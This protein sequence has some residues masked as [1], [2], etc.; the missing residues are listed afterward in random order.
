[1]GI[2]KNKVIVERCNDYDRKNVD[3]V[4][5]LFDSL[6][7]ETIGH[8]ETVV[9]KPN[10]IAPCHKYNADEWQ[11]VI[12][13]PRFISGVVRKV[14]RQLNGKGKIVIAD[15][16]QT[17]TVFSTLVGRM[18][19]DEWTRACNEQG[20]DLEVLDLRDHEWTN[21]GDIIIS[22]KILPG[23][24]MGSVE[25]NLRDDMSEFYGHQ[26]SAMGYYGA[27]CDIKETNLAHANGNHLYRVSRT[28]ISAD[29]FINLP[30]WKTHKKAGITCSL[31]NLVGI[32]TYKNYLPHHTE[33]TPA[34]GGDQFPSSNV[35]SALEVYLLEY[36]K[37]ILL[38]YDK[39]SRYMIPV[40]KLGKVI[41]GA[42]Q[43][44]IRSGNWYGNDTLW[45]TILDLNKILLYGNT[46]GTMKEAEV[47]RGKKYLSF[48]DG[49]I[50]GEG[51]GP[52]APDPL[53][54]GIIIGGSNPVSVDCVAARLMGFDHLKIPSLYKTF[55]MKRF[56]IADFSYTDVEVMSKTMPSY[57]S[58]LIDISKENCF[59]FKPHFGWVH[60][61][62]LS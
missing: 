9:I 48:V 49:I 22:R 45:R 54:T 34:M 6:F 16:P 36:F 25:Y 40:K 61:I 31:K 13:H 27:D 50:A 1:M 53:N 14:I 24:P 2:L 59:C 60:N 43:D 58:P 46:D 26:P 62:E 35:K 29:V 10:W 4:L 55:H 33:G 28:V 57:N 8:G 7:A 56:P 15:A 37:K 51:N 30:K 23:D 18:P 42:T 20:I 52:E 39:Y 19:I 47:S 11:S 44:K 38:R 41:F 5:D 17:D 3:E 12:T 32:N 21:E